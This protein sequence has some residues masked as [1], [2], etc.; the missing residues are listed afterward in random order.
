MSVAEA[1][2]G[3]YPLAG[4]QQ[5]VPV[6]AAALLMGRQ[7]PSLVRFGCDPPAGNPLRHEVQTKIKNTLDS[8]SIRFS[9]RNQSKHSIDVS[10]CFFPVRL[11]QFPAEDFTGGI[12]GNDGREL[13]RFWQLVAGNMLARGFDEVV[14]LRRPPWL[15]DDDGLDRFAPAL[16]GN[17]D[18][19]DICDVR[20]MKER[21]LDFS[22]ID[23]LS[24]RHDHLLDAVVDVEIALLVEISRIARV[25]PA[26][27]NGPGG[28]G[29][30]LPIALR[31]DWP[32][33]N[34]FAD[35]AR[36]ADGAGR[37]DDAHVGARNRTPAR[38]QLVPVSVVIVGRQH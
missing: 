6:A 36:L 20:M 12:A 17:P 9:N 25:Q 33:D 11:A 4:L 26:V 30:I 14:R 24:A 15:H 18:N 34:H 13:D 28:N 29:L 10:A 37:A 23:I 32:P 16:I 1:M 21:V 22:G 2:R 35:F 8:A 5:A 27:D 7:Y 19:G 38:E 3:E 31:H